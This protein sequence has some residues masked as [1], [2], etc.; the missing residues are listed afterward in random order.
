MKEFIETIIKYLVDKPDEVQVTEK[1][2]ERT[3]ICE[4]RVGD[5]DY[6]KIIG[7]HGNTAVSLRVL[8]GAVSKKLGKHTVFEI[9]DDNGRAKPESN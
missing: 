6:G 7:K 4:A 3:L 1:T 9:L 5:G 2:G 8:V